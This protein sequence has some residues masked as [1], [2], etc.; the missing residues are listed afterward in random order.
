MTT[1][2]GLWKSTST[3]RFR[4]LKSI[5]GSLALASAARELVVIEYFVAF[6]LE[7]TLGSNG[8]Q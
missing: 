5:S 4:D 6:G 2:V 7:L 3:E 8:L 1:G